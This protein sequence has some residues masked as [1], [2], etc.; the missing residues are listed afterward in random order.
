MPPHFRCDAG[1][2]PATEAGPGQ[3]EGSSST[4]PFSRAAYPRRR[5]ALGR[6]AGIIAP[7]PRFAQ[8]LALAVL[9]AIV[10]N[11]QGGGSCSSLGFVGWHHNH[12]RH[13]GGDGGG[14]GHASGGAEGLMHAHGARFCRDDGMQGGMQLGVQV[15]AIGDGP[16]SDEHDHD[17]DHG[18]CC[19]RC[20]GES[21][22]DPAAICEDREWRSAGGRADPGDPVAV[23]APSECLRI[24]WLIAGAR[25]P[26][27][28]PEA[29]G[30]TLARI[31]SVVLMM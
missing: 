21:D 14:G 18:R 16:A 10:L 27:P 29:S 22:V 5:E 4:L 7:M 30:G 20:G 1:S 24:S 31:R 9:I 25:P 23:A 12:H 17:H 13:S 26:P 15:G 11:W 2:L 28:H 19:H 8:F 6:P 3:G